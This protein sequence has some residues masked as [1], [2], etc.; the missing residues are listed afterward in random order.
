MVL[1]FT[2][3]TG[4]QP[5]A[6]AAG[7]R[8]PGADNSTTNDTNNSAADNAAAVDESI[9]PRQGSSDDLSYRRQSESRLGAG[10]GFNRIPVVASDVGIFM[11]N[12]NYIYWFSDT[13]DDP[14]KIGLGINLA[15]LNII[16]PIPHLEINT[17][18]PLFS[19]RH[20]GVVSAGAFYD[21][22]AANQFS[23]SARI[24]FRFKK[25]WELTLYGMLPLTDAE[26]EYS[27]IFKRKEKIK[28]LQQQ[29]GYG[30][31]S[32]PYVVLLISRRLTFGD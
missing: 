23:L 17:T 26:I 21:L 12:L 9:L 7:N 1:L 3:W 20:L 30:K 31:D 29:P 19:R 6:A 15:F 25:N 10:G 22:L 4:A 11:V 2:G 5:P 8:K 13:R 27:D 28:E 24:G 16:I 18:F 14:L 32:K